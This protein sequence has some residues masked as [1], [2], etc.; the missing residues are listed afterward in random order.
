M[1]ENKSLWHQGT[2]PTP[3]E[4]NDI[5]H[6][7]ANDILF[8]VGRDGAIFRKSGAN[9]W[10]QCQSG[11]GK[12]DHIWGIAA[13]LSSTLV[14]G[15]RFGF[16]VKSMDNGVSWTSKRK[17][18]TDGDGESITRIAFGNDIF[19]AILDKGKSAGSILS[20]RDGDSWT[21]AKAGIPNATSIKFLNGKFFIGAKNGAIFYGN[22]A[23][24]WNKCDWEISDI[25]FEAAR[26]LEYNTE[27][28]TYFAA[29]HQVAI[30]Q[31]G[32]TWSAVLDLTKNPD[33]GNRN[34][35][36]I[37]PVGE[38][39][40]LFGE[41]LLILEYDGS[42]FTQVGGLGKGGTLGACL[43]SD[44]IICVGTYGDRYILLSDLE[45]A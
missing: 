24:S 11:F 35:H 26:A 40:Y 20:S 2:I 33:W 5:Y 34:I 44:R 22:G 14:A 41:D 31:D 4:L 36:A 37:V 42:N 28:G 27:T 16:I 25:K 8:T 12:N 29:G 7:S 38:K 19:L 13:N 9:N 45:A 10:T 3:R 18:N 15:G 6:D 30:S 21:D 1:N 43:L 17:K 39:T 23:A 32:Q